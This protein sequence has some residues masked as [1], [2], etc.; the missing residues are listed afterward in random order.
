MHPNRSR[1]IHVTHEQNH[2]ATTFTLTLAC[3]EHEARHADLALEKAHQTIADLENELSEFLPH[4]PVARWNRALVGEGVAMP[5]SVTEI[6]RTSENVWTETAGGFD[7]FFR[8]PPDVLAR[9]WSERTRIEKSSGDPRSTILVKIAAGA[10]LG[11]GA[12]GK[13]YALDQVRTGLER[14]GF[15]HY[16]LSAGGSSTVISGESSPGDPWVWGW[17]WE[18][19][20]V[21]MVLTHTRRTPMAIGVSGIEEK[22]FHIV[23]GARPA[24]RL[25]SALVIE[26]SAAVADARST[27][28]LARGWDLAPPVA[29]AIPWDGSTILRTREALSV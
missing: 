21:G 3:A 10:H 11:F 23:D 6:L 5:R 28:M 17:S 7:C 16:L 2:M 20:K 1:W 14:E 18:K 9:P 26:N 12:I 29:A 22:G 13:G 19:G 4:S 15:Q 8:S 24:A 27:A 25:R